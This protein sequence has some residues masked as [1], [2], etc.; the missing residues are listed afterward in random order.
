MPK[1][2]LDLG[3]K[4]FS[5]ESSDESEAQKNSE[6]LKSEEPKKESKEE[7]KES[8]LDEEYEV[9][10]VLDYKWCLATVSVFMKCDLVN[11]EFLTLEYIYQLLPRDFIFSFKI[12]LNISS[13]I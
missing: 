6:K 13:G 10:K 7:E 5:D 12:I 11:I 2:N 8:V 4:E 1:S 3:P 9:E